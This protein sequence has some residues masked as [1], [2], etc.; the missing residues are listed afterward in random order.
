MKLSNSKPLLDIFR[1]MNDARKAQNNQIGKKNY[2]M[3]FEKLLLI[4]KSE[5][6]SLFNEKA[7]TEPKKYVF[8]ILL[9][10]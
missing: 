10:K 6:H 7:K 9:I 3:K 1:L 5:Y 8:K 2:D 4:L